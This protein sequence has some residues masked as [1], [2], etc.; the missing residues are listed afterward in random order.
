MIQNNILNPY[1]FIYIT[2]NM[3]NGMQYIG[4][5]KFSKDWQYYLG[6]GQLLKKA[7]KK[8]GRENFIRDIIAI[9][10]SS[11]ELNDLEI[12]FINNHNAVK[13]RNYYNISTGGNC[14]NC[15]AGKS[16]SEMNEIKN[17]ISLLF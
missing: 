9:A 15:F 13:D 2:T 4:Q 5:R 11:D 1:G 17:K 14:G 12:Q 3:C 6:S 10:Y 7:I 16:D 8:Y